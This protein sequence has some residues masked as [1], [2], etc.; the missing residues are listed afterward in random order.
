MIKIKKV[1]KAKALKAVKDL[2]LWIGEDPSRE[3]LYET[4]DRFLLALEEKMQGYKK[5]PQDI[6]QKQFSETANYSGIIQL[7][8]IKIESLCEH[9]LAPIIGRAHLAYLPNNKVVGLSKLAR[10]V[11]IF[12]HR[13]QLQERLT[14]QIAQALWDNLKPKG[15]AIQIIAK[16]HCMNHRGVKHDK[17]FMVTEQFLG[18][19][20]NDYALQKKFLETF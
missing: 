18:E 13:L 20:K 6:L 1:T 14:S 4:P 2:L 19:F 7:R 10:L 17:A 9:H 11:E 8:N 12:T 16:H 15:V 5:N 3:G